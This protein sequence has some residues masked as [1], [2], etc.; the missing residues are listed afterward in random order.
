MDVMK[1]PPNKT[2][3]KPKVV[4]PSPKGIPRPEPISIK[5][6]NDSLSD[7]E[8]FVDAQDLKGR[9][10]SIEDSEDFR[11]A[12]DSFDEIYRSESGDEIC[13][14]S[15]RTQNITTQ[16]IENSSQQFDALEAGQVKNVDGAA[17]ERKGSNKF[18]KKKQQSSRPGS[19]NRNSIGSFEEQE[20]D[21][22]RV[23]SP[24]LTTRLAETKEH[25]QRLDNTFRTLVD[26]EDMKTVEEGYKLRETKG[27]SLTRTTVARTEDP[28][29]QAIETMITKRTI[30][31]E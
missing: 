30:S 1:P 14:S 28:L 4:V 8:F 13:L 31:E 22:A 21:S 7:D 5:T 12:V 11:R 29:D 6:S 3:G 15:R 2:G 25:M 27:H 16:K 26:T 20:D 17:R 23:S 18:A 24:D 19:G 9:H 10:H